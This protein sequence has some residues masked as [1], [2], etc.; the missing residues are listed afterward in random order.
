MTITT[1]TNYVDYIG[2]G[3]T[4]V[5]PYTFRV[6]DAD[7]FVLERTVIATNITTTILPAEY[8]YTGIGVEG[9][10]NITYP[11][12]G[13]PLPATDRLRIQR[14]VTLVQELNIA[15]QSA[16][17]PEVV[18]QQL[19]LLVMMIQQIET[20]ASAVGSVEWGN[21][22]NKPTTLGG[23][24]ITD[25]QALDATLTALAA[26]SATAGLLEQTGADTFVKRAIG[27]AAATSILSRDDGDTRFAALAHIHA[28]GD[29]ISIPDD[30]VELAALTTVAYGRGLLESA[31][32]NAAQVYLGLELGVDVQP[33]GQTLSSFEGLT[34]AAGDI[35]FATGP[36]TVAALPAGADGQFLRLNAGLPDWEAIPG[37]GDALTANPLSQFAATSSAQLRG[38]MSDESGTGAL[39]FAGGDIGAGSGTTAAPG[40]NSTLL[41]T[42]AFVKEAIDV[43][44]GGVASAF[45]TL[46]EIATELA[47]KAYATVTL[48]ASTGLTGGGDLSANRSFAIDKASDANVRAAASNKVIT[49]DL[50]ESASAAVALSSAAA[51]IAVDWDAGINFT[52]T[53]TEN[54]TLANPTNGQPGTWRRF[55]WTQ[56]ASAPKTLAWGTQY[57]GP[58]GGAVTVTP[59]NSAVD[60]FMIYCRTTSIFEVYAS[61]AMADITP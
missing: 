54:T 18:E 51:S 31:N 38:V 19:D 17:L 4:T 61:L 30:L 35:F 34:L 55:Q 46:L 57:V 12:V 44:L 33:L 59:T 40:T 53:A 45:D 10:G 24:N 58:G 28:W 41:A 8:S 26:L 43:V 1:Q 7:H 39:I 56:H 50:I 27:V 9:G 48:T 49:A 25:A 20:A 16:F 2:N 47:L 52:H 6:D 32:E 15:N 14:R 3:V 60:V 42:T 21:I 23:F 11:L 29:L 22:T 13:S 36:D 37:G 5:F